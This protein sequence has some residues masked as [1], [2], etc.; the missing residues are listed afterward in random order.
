MTRSLTPAAARAA[1]EAACWNGG[2]PAEA[3]PA[4]ALLLALALQPECRAGE[5]LTAVGVDAHAIRQRWPELAR[6]EQVD[7]ELPE[8]AL[9]VRRVM[10][11]AEGQFDEFSQPSSLATEH[12]LLGIAAAA[13]PAADWLTER[14]LPLARVVEEVERLHGVDRTPIAWEDAGDLQARTGDA[15]PPEGPRTRVQTAA[16]HSTDAPWRMIDAAANR[17]RE[18]LRVLEDAARFGRDDRSAAASLKGLRHELAATLERF[19]R[20]LLLLARD[21][22]GDVGAD[23]STPREVLRGDLG[24]VVTANFKRL[25]ESLRSLE[26]FGKLIDVAAAARFE[27]LRYLSYALEAQGR[28]EA[29]LRDRLAAARLYV[30]LDGR[31]TASAF[32]KTA[33]ELV[34]GGVDV[35]QLRDKRLPDRELLGRAEALRRITRDAPTLC[36]VN[37][38]PDLA[39]LSAA[40]GVHVGQGELT[41][42]ECRRIVGR[43]A[44]VGVSTHSIE[45]ARAAVA[46]GA[47]YIGLGPVFASKTKRFDALPGLELVR[48]VAAEISLPGFAIGGIHAGNLHEVLAAGAS[49][50]AVSAAV[51][52]AAEP[53]VAARELSRRLAR[54]DEQVE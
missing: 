38:R 50:V 13:G 1:A 40:D 49:R 48:A 9:S 17:A 25:Q 15:A 54:L 36:I 19:P 34:E 22:A 46:A 26:E 51:A 39:R 27:R 8:A 45:Q 32:E 37:D 33:S 12:L 14:G 16:S 5:L 18:A 23:L 20:H 35:L 11:A 30:L 53:A 28:A 10:L 3:D 41:V 47:D 44:L 43:E 6:R 7:A 2:P 52:D 29:P 42:A 21:V 31:E 24:D 4:I